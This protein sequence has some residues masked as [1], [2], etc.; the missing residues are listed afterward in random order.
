[1]R[2][3]LDENLPAVVGRALRSVGYEY[4][5][6]GDSPAPPKQSS[7]SAIARWCYEND[8]V[9]VTSDR[10]R[11]NPEIIAA[12]GAFAICVV[13]LPNGWTAKELL[14]FLVARG[15]R[16]EQKLMSEG[17]GASVR[18]RVHKRGGIQR[19]TR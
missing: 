19:I 14:W 11:K 18:V 7:D 13:F 16:L 6:I 17:L 2:Y 10:G 8:A 3:L 15:E 5:V 12:L 1:L 4:D 9:L